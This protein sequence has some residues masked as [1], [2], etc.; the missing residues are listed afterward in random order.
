MKAKDNFEFHR[1]GNDLTIGSVPR[2]MISFSFPML[3]ASFFHTAYSFINA[4]WV[5]QFL[6]T[7]SLAAITVSF[8]IVFILLA[9][10]TG[11]TLAANILVSQSYGSKNFRTVRKVVDNS[12]NLLAIISL[13]LLAIGELLAPQILILAGTPPDVLPLAISYLRIFLFS[14]PLTFGLFLLRNVLQGI[15]D[16]KTTL[17]FQATSIILSAI[18]DPMLMFG[19][20]SQIFPRLGLNGTAYATVFSQ[21]FALITVIIYLKKKKNLVAPRWS[22]FSL[23]SHTAWKLIRIGVPTALQQALISMGMVCVVSIVN[24][25]GATVTAAWGA[26]IRI[27]HLAMMPAM[28]LSGAISALSGQNIGAQKFERIKEIFFWGVIFNVSITLVVSILALTIPELLLRIFVSDLTV[29][30]AGVRYLNIMGYFYLFFALTFVSNGIINGSG[31]TLAITIF[32]FVSLWFVRVPLA[33]FLSIYLHSE[34][35]IWYGVAISF[36]C[37]TCLSFAYYFSGRWKRPLEKVIII[38]DE[39]IND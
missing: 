3:L 31:H 7:S 6:G 36:V 2:K 19:W 32:S 35:G 29:I 21:A 28:T 8:P 4:I 30:N 10:A 22:G 34:I 26:A 16:S 37:S 15:G 14:L 27:D 1:D 18:L 11:L 13:L 12:T 25:Y 5:G 9:V 23:D 33:H 17:Y 39:Q 20:P 38:A 24:R